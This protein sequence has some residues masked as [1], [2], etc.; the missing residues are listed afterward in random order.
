MILCLLGGFLFAAENPYDYPVSTV[1]VDAGH[2][3]HDPGAFSTWPFHDGV[4]YERD[5]NLD[6]ATR[7]RSILAERR[8]DIEIVMTRSDDTYVS[9]EKRSQLAYRTPLPAKHSAL[10]VSIHTNSAE[11]PEARGFEVLMKQQKK[12]VTLLDSE[13]PLENISLFAPYTA[14]ELNRFLNNRNLVVASMFRQALAEGLPD[15]LD[16]GTKEQDLHVLN[17]SRVPAVLVEIGF[18]SNEQDAR[19]LVSPTWRQQV[20]EAIA[21]A[22]VDCL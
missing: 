15:S 10:F 16:R 18:L 19:N 20:S 21:Q 8:P 3:G 5:I 1:I 12:S 2:G 11:N 13:T 9:L 6:V 4:L 22:I 17:A 14:V 7:V